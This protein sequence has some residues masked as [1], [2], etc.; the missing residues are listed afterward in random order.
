MNHLFVEKNKYNSGEKKEIKGKD[1]HLYRMNK[2]KNNKNLST[3]MF[4]NC[5]ACKCTS[6]TNVQKDSGKRCSN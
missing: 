4:T 2:Q 1:F 6:V 3:K 5:S